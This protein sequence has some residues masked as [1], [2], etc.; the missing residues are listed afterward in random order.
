[1]QIEEE[2]KV[3][4]DDVTWP[5]P[6]P[7][8]VDMSHVEYHEKR[9]RAYLYYRP[10]A[11]HRSSAAGGRRRLQSA[12][13][14]DREYDSAS[15]SSEEDLNDSVQ[16]TGL[17]L[18]ALQ[19]NDP[20]VFKHCIISIES[21]RNIFAKPLDHSYPRIAI[22]AR[23]LCG[24]AFHGDEVLMEIFDFGKKLDVPNSVV[25]SV[26]D[27]QASD[28]VVAELEGPWA[29]TVGVFKRAMNPKYRMFVCQVEDGNTGVMVPLNCGVPKIFNLE[30][31][32]APTEEGKVTI[33]AFTKAK[34][35][36]FDRYQKVHDV[37]SVLFVVRYLKWEDRCSLPL[38]IV[39][40]M[41]PPGVTVESAMSILDIEYSIPRRFR[42]ATLAEVKLQ[43]SAVLSQ[44]PPGVLARRSDYR[45]SLVFTIDPPNSRDLDD[46]LSFEV[47]PDGTSYIIGIHITDVSYFVTK[48]SSIDCEARQRGSSFFTAVGDSTPMLPPRLSTDLC[49]LLPNKDRLT[50]SVYIKVNAGADILG[51]EIKRSIV[52]SCHQLCY[53]EAE[54]IINGLA[55]DGDYS[56]ELTCALMSLYRVAQLWRSKRLGREAL[57]TAVDYSTLDGPKAHKLVEEM[58]IAAN[59]Q[60]AVYLLSKFPSYTAVRC[61]SPPDVTDLEEWKTR[62][63]IA[64]HQSIVLSRPYCAAGHVCQ[65]VGLCECLPSVS[66]D[67]QPA[68][69][70]DGGRGFEMMLPLWLQIQRAFAFDEFDNDRLQSL[71]ISPEFHPRQAVALSNYQQI[72]GRSAYRCSGELETDM[73]RHHH[74]LNLPVYVQFTSPLRRYIDLVTHR[75]VH[76]ALD[77]TGPCYTQSDLTELCTHC[78]DVALRTRRYERA[79]L[80]AHFCDLLMKRPLVLFAVVDRITDTDIQLLFPTIQSFFPSRTKVK[81]SS[82]NTGSRPVIGS[83]MEHLLVMWSQRIYDCRRGGGLSRRRGVMEVRS[84]QYTFVIPAAAWNDLLLASVDEDLATTHIADALQRI[85]PYAVLPQVQEPTSEGFEAVDGK[86]FAEYSLSVH[87]GSVVMVQLSTELHRGLLRPCVQLFH[88]TPQSTCV[89]VEHITAAVKCFCKVA[90]KSAARALYSS[91]GKYRKL[92]LPVLAME[93]V[94]GAIANQHSVIIHNVDIQWTPHR[95]HGEGPV[96][97]AMFKL[98]VS[99]CESRCIRF[100]GEACDEDEVDDSW[101]PDPRDDSCHGYICVRYAG[102]SMPVPRIDLPIGHLVNL[103]EHLTWVG[104]CTVSK[105]LLVDKSY[106]R[107]YLKVHQSSFPPP[108]QLLDGSAQPATVEWIDKPLPD[109]FVHHL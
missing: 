68:D 39:I 27:K 62:F 28:K 13:D 8:P 48:S 71:V 50:L 56:A 49:S 46:A 52:R 43:H 57:Y 109:R 95:M 29:K 78:T 105:V 31:H 92:W 87:A 73:D 67:S 47:S 54:A 77:D 91:A 20:D 7:R 74:S 108:A 14:F 64:A 16:Y 41:L 76:C 94:H 38:G 53:S 45:N 51:V 5:P 107:I 84:D 80:V 55:D 24:R 70:A 103:T 15:D 36:I 30:R 83:D 11:S 86:H 72:Q 90:T 34:Q 23:K 12:G 26:V 102:I 66:D 69:A 88:V 106:F 93:A 85:T 96:Y 21:S 42:E 104:H 97:L 32:D 99:F 100:A 58:M 4:E 81:L 2:R 33:Y 37:N 61:Q 98:P 82:L 60:V 35:I 18:S 59:H 10:T 1:V 6:Q 40:S 75:L 25:R 63:L 65:C 44:F 79:N 17:E 9:G 89:C 3:K 19:A 101:S 22:P